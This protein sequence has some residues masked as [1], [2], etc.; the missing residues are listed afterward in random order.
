MQ[1]TLHWA[2]EV[3]EGAELRW[4]WRGMWGLAAVSVA[5]LV[6]MHGSGNWRALSL[7]SLGLWWLGWRW[8]PAAFWDTGF[9]VLKGARAHWRQQEGTVEWIWLG[10]EILGLWFIPAQAPRVAI[11]LTRRRVGDV[12]WWQ[13]KRALAL[14]RPVQ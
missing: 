8:R 6:W 5:S 11:W 3:G 12:A 1:Q 10:D 14:H 9:L 4:I 13:L 2:A 7:L